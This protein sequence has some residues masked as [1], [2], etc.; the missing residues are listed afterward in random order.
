MSEQCR[1][2]DRQR[3]PG[4]LR[5]K[6]SGQQYREQPFQKIAAEADFSGGFADGTG[7]I[8]R[9]D[10]AGADL[11]D[12]HSVEFADQEAEW[13]RTDQIGGDPEEE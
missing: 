5:Q 13:N 9:A 7:H 12:V 10:V 6:E 2:A 4:V 3:Q 11:A 8:G 1:E